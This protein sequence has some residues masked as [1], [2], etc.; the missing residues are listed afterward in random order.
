M[1][2]RRIGIM[3][4]TFDPIHI[5][6]LVIAEAVYETYRLDKVL[7]IPASAPPHKP[8]VKV[9]PALHRYVMTV[10][11]T[12]GHPAFS[13]SDIEMRRPGP[14]YS[15]DTVRAL[16]QE[17]GEACEFFFILGTDAAKELGTWNNVDELLDLCHFVAATR[18]GTQRAVDEVIQQ[19]GAK[20]QAKIHPLSTPELAISSTDIRGRIQAGQSVRFILPEQVEAY[21]KKEGL[22]R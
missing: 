7:F 20:G 17:M 14:S 5:G 8:G 3:G 18:P 21:I 10:L 1:E 22:Y 4:G 15:Y 16:R 11:A 2:K 9:A 13:V 12:V 19:F 6:H